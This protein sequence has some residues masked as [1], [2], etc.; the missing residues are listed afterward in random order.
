LRQLISSLVEVIIFFSKNELGELKEI[1]GDVKRWKYMLMA[2][3]KTTP[4]K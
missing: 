3:A 4:V 1:G 2:G